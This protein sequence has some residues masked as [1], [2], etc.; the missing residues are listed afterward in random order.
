MRVTVSNDRGRTWSEEVID[1]HS[2]AGDAL[3]HSNEYHVRDEAG[4]VSVI[5]RRVGRQTG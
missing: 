4:E 3:Q 5:V 1:R 2:P